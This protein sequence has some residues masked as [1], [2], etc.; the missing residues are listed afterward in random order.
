MSGKAAVVVVLI[1]L[2]AGGA[3]AYYF[4]VM[5][6]GGAALPAEALALPADTSMVMGL[7]VKKFMGTVRK[8][9]DGNFAGLPLPPEAMAELPKAKGEME[10]GLKELEEKT[11]VRLE[12][13]VDQAVIGMQGVG[14]APEPKAV[15]LVVGRFDRAKVTAAIEKGMKE[16]GATPTVKDHAGAKVFTA[17]DNAAAVAS[18]RVLV[19]GTPALVDSTLASI[20]QKANTL[21]PGLASLVG[22]VRGGS[23]FWL[24]AGEALMSAAGKQAGPMPVSMP[25]SFVVSDHAD[26]GIEV[27]AQMPDA[28]SASTAATMIKGGL[29]MAK[30]Q[31]GDN[32]AIK[33][34]KPEVSA[35]GSEVRLS[36]K[37]PAGLGG[38]GVGIMA[39]V[40]IPS[41]L[42]ARVAAN[43]AGTIGDIRAVISAEAAY[44]AYT[45]SR[46]EFGELRCLSE[47]KSC[48]PEYDGPT[49]LDPGITTL[50]DKGGY[51][52][53][54]F[55]G[56]AGSTP[57][58]IQ[59]YAYTAAPV[60][61]GRTG[62]R[63]FCGDESGV[64]CVNEDGSPFDASG[65]RCP[66]GC[67][68]LM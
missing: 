6:A 55:A 10:K 24:V 52:R 48:L 26:A 9:M 19:F 38:A 34:L 22:R 33:D 39:A 45:P 21:N 8:L 50:A 5:K 59:S 16:G 36:V 18:E 31:A 51:K 54:F 30:A 49:F 2:L 61:P 32:P 25:K 7:D 66:A 53:S 11:G 42:R 15:V 46:V 23:T 68:P 1:L 67:T 43:E 3:A 57:G 65:G 63:S 40:A 14:G 27:L 62:V 41:L 60:Q 13:D 29:E 20:A 37:M 17:G 28:Q 56:A 35:S 47:P 4:L 64:I 12:Q 44:Q 58:A